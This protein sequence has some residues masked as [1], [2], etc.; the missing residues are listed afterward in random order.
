MVKTSPKLKAIPFIQ[1]AMT[2]HTDKKSF[3]SLQKGNKILVPS[4]RGVKLIHN[5]VYNKGTA[6]SLE[7]RRSLGL[8]GLL[9]PCP[10]S[11][12]TQADR[13]ISNIRKTADDLD[14]YVQLASLQD[15]N[16]HL[17][18]FVLRRHLEELMP[19]VYTPTVGK[20][21]QRFGDIFRRSRGMYLSIEDKGSI[22]EI[23]LNW[24]HRD[25]GVIVVTDGSRI[26]GLGDLGLNGM[27]IPIGKLALYTA[28]AG[29]DPTNCLPITVDV[30]TNNEALLKDPLYLGHKHHRKEG[31]EYTAFFDEFIDAVQELFPDAIIQFED[32]STA[33]AFHL[34]KRFKNKARVFNDDIQGTASV[35]LAG[36]LAALR[37]TGQQ[38]TD[39][40]IL[41]MGAGEAGTGIGDMISTAL[42]EA[43]L[44]EEQARQQNWFVDSKGLVCK[45]REDLAPHKLPYAHEH[46]PTDTFTDVIRSLRPT[47]IIGVSGQGG[48]F[49]EEV[50]RLMS[51]INERPIIFA[52]SNPTSKSECTAEQAYTWSEGKAIFASGSPFAP[53]ERGDRRLIPGQG[54]NVYIFPGVGLGLSYC[55]SKIVTDRMFYEA[56][57]VLANSVTEEELAQGTVYPS[58]QRILDISAHIAMAVVRVAVE[59]GMVLGHYLTNMEQRIKNS[60][61]TPDYAEFR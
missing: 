29:V 28:C 12:D 41:F 38:L 23:L 7:E 42:Q 40:K 54:N 51:E 46:P 11:Q 53:V 8:R 33:N 2:N 25:V 24:P 26:L 6:F 21:C 32:F 52:L 50:V 49:T 31:D 55:H 43:G 16:E 22:K 56:A 17:F 27:G 19:I 36:L 59:D 15:R 18:Y 57:R 9:P 47:A 60:M 37:I 5:P 61:Y 35:A 48:Q 1:I 3:E 45:A 14:K 58:F 39:Q 34:L 13:V 20:A 10:L 4:E 30:G 44:P